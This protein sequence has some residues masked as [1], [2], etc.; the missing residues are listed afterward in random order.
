MTNWQITAKTIFCDAVDDEVTVLVYKNGSTRCTGCQKYNQ[1]NS[2]TLGI[3]R[4]KT[5][6][7]KRA[8]K[9]RG[10]TMPRVYLN[11]KRKSWQKKPN[12]MAESEKPIIS[13]QLTDNLR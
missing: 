5:R 11:I 2:I 6:R 3:I 12:N 13:T 7:L 10:R 8:D 9:M 1:P 4:E